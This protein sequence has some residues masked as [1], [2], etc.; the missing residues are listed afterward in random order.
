MIYDKVLTYYLLWTVASFLAQLSTRQC[1]N[2]F[3]V[4]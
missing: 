1:S 4:W 3:N 2:M